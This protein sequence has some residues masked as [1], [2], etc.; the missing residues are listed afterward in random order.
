MPKS[1][2]PK[3]EEEFEKWLVEEY[4]KYGSVN[5]V[6]RK[7]RYA[8]PISYAGYQRVLDKWGIVKAAG[9]NNKLTEA[10]EFLSYLAH[11]NLP[12]D[13][14]YKNIPPSFQTSAVT[15]Y[16]ILGYVKEGITRRV[17][18]ALVITPYN[19]R[20]KVLIGRDIS[21]PKIE[22]GKYYGS[23]SLPMGYSRKRDSRK[24]NI[25]RVLQQ[26]LF[27]KKV[28]ERAFPEEVIPED[29]VPFM[30]LDIADVR[31]SVY[32]IQLPKGLSTAT[33][34]SSY[35]LKD[36]SFVD[37]DKIIDNKLENLRAGVI[38][39][40]ITY[41]KYFEFLDRNLVVNPLQAKS[42]LNETLAV[43]TVDVEG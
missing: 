13:K 28:L 21:T 17:G 40:V 5:E 19:S 30:Y 27:T 1:K 39:T 9:P 41:K 26:E 42:L 23:F 4:F 22:L 35:K 43:V 32:H 2:F 6:F 15:L 37:T 3:K 10:L 31:V 25:L 11:E 20:E 29:P 33:N 14:I 24:T 18:T 8:I 36:Y 16:R 38:E 7:Y 34:F 12:F